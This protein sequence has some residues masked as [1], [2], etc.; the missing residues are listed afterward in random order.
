MRVRQMVGE[1]RTVGLVSTVVVGAGLKA[2]VD[3]D[4]RRYDEE[5]E[6]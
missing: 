4:L 3:A 2:G 6:A 1:I 5:A